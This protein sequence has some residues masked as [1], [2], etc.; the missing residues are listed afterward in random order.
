MRGWFSKVSNFQ[1]KIIVCLFLFNFF[2]IIFYLFSFGCIGSLL[3][4]TGFL[5]L[6]RAGGLPPHCG[7]LASHCSG[8]SC[9]GVQALGTWTS[10]VTTCRFSSC[11]SWPPECWLSHGGAQVELL[12]GMWNFP[13]PGIEPVSLTLAGRFLST[14][15]PGKS[16]ISFFLKTSL[17]PQAFFW[18]LLVSFIRS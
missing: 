7:V 3:L 8:F 5:Q 13:G 11:S 16:Y 12:L 10:V 9:C 18:N 14:A 17:F 1:W 2:P 15:L 6:W 4:L